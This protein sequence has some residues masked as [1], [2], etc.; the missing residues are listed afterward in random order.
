MQHNISMAIAAFNI[1]IWPLSFVMA[2]A[3]CAKVC[4]SFSLYFSL[5][6]FIMLQRQQ[7]KW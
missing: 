4:L 3:M 5:S 1:F 2:K 7:V 6:P